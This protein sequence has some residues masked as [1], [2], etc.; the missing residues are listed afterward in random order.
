M[1]LGKRVGTALLCALLLG[2]SAPAQE[3]EPDRP[4]RPG[5]RGERGEREAGR[6]RQRGGRRGP[7]R[8]N[9]E[10]VADRLDL[11]PDQRQ[12][13]LEL[14]QARTESRRQFFREQGETFREVRRK[15]RE[16]REA[17]D[18]ATVAELRAQ[19]QQLIEKMRGSWRDT[20]SQLKELLGAEGM[21]KLQA[22]TRGR[23]GGGRTNRRFGDA[24]ETL[25]AVEKMP[26]LTDEQR[27]KIEELRKQYDRD[28]QEGQGRSGRRRSWRV[29]RDAMR[30]LTNEQQAKLRATRTDR[31]ETPAPG[32][33][34]AEGDLAPEANLPVAEPPSYAALAKD[35]VVPVVAR[36]TH[37]FEE[38][39]RDFIERYGL[40]DAQTTVAQAAL[41][42]SKARAGI[43]EIRHADHFTRISDRLSRI[44]GSSPQDQKL[45]ASLTAEYQKLVEPIEREL[46]RLR[47][48]LDRIPTS[49]QRK[50]PTTKPASPTT[51]PAPAAS[52]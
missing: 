37:R 41:S 38:Y 9:W 52:P 45:R 2:A 12:S 43:H 34:R 39:V 22:E 23:F 30:V 15:T 10:Q 1:R 29:V 4:N 5:V 19:R 8:I 44:T 46:T 32:A 16:A 40:D 6:Q 28:G 48:R 31:R 21:E 20:E 35:P 51:K 13:F 33:S 11:Q 7:R 14:T 49:A 42:A 25:R 27:G 17:G 47:K 36:P 50:T 18:E 3:A 24:A 26:D